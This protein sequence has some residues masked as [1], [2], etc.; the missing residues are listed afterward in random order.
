M[1]LCFSSH[2]LSPHFI[3]VL[4][5]V[6]SYADQHFVYCT[7]L[8]ST[9]MLAYDYIHVHTS[10]VHSSTQ[11]EGMSAVGSGNTDNNNDT[12]AVLEDDN[13]DMA[14]DTGTHIHINFYIHI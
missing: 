3:A 9:H 12:D 5:A 1:Q 7:L 4:K 14:V 8:R 13:N 2:L 6:I 11:R 10:V